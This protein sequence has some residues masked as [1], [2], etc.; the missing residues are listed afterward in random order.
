MV[1]L[2]SRLG[3][4]ERPATDLLRLRLSV[5][6]NLA[7]AQ[8]EVVGCLGELHRGGDAVD[9]RNAEGVAD[10][11]AQASEGGTAQA[12]H[13]GPVHRDGGPALCDGGGARCGQVILQAEH[14]DAGGAYR[15]APVGES[16]QS[17]AIRD[18]GHG[19][20]DARDDAI[21]AAEETGHMRG[22]LRDVEDRH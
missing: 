4:G 22:G 10:L 8:V 21:R 9:D 6:V 16:G 1:N 11:F 20:V 5:G 17:K 3:V 14:R 12:D 19:P 2:T 18:L 13:L 7:R 15:S